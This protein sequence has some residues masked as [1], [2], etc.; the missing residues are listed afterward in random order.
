[1]G[2]SGWNYSLKFCKIHKYTNEWVS[3]FVD[4]KRCVDGHQLSG[5]LKCSRK[6]HIGSCTN[7]NS[8]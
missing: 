1:M 7:D 2:N 3:E 4:V 8:P 6:I 5:P